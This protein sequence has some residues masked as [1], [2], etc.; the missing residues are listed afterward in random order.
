MIAAVLML[1]CDI[2]NASKYSPPD[3]AIPSQARP[4]KP[5]LAI[6][7]KPEN[8]PK[9]SSQQPHQPLTQLTT[10]GVSSTLLP[11]LPP[12]P[13]AQSLL[14]QMASLASKVFEVSPN[15]SHWISA[16]RGSLPSFLSPHTQSL[17]TA[18]PDSAKSGPRIL[19]CLPEPTNLRKMRM[20]LT[21]LL[22][23]ALTTVTLK[24]PS[25]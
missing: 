5:Q 25:Q 11:L 15:R 1:F 18:Q 16:F 7:S 10:P 3:C 20:F 21:F 13:R 19:P 8:P 6:Y 14:L 2:Q 17:T 9:F 24:E 12:L 4:A 22:M 23:I